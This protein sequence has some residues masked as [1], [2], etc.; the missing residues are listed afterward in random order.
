[1][2][3]Q[4][5]IMRRRVIAVAI[6]LGCT[7]VL[8]AT[9]IR[10]TLGSSRVT[11]FF[12]T[13]FKALNGVSLNGQSLSL[14]FVFT[15]SF[16]RLLPPPNFPQTGVD[17]DISVALH[18]N[19]GGLPGFGSGTGFIFDQTGRPLEA[20][21]GLGS[22]ASDEGTIYLGLFPLL[23]EAPADARFYGFHMDIT[24]PNN[25]GFKITD[26]DLRLFGGQI[27]VR[28]HVIQG[29][30]G[31]GPHVADTGS[32]AILLAF[33]LSLLTATSKL[34]GLGRQ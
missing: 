5:I 31:I 26:E 24:L 20:P 1:M 15:D 25:P 29:E 18:T 16:I 6:F 11:P 19:A 28:D 27:Q 7:A 22:A 23:D 14:N 2:H 33:A 12:A 13:P 4:G 30:F 10:I 32:T 3:Q 21:V 9:P 17:F 34:R 8:N